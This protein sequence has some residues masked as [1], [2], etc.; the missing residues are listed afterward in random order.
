MQEIGFEPPGPE[1]A[2]AK[3]MATHC[4]ILAW[5]IPKTEEPGGFQSMGLQRVGQDRAA[6]TFTFR[7]LPKSSKFVPIPSYPPRLFRLGKG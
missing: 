6:N 5:K 7:G 3:E 1:D 2:L 4:S